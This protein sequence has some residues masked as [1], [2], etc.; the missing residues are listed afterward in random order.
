[1]H[2]QLQP[3]RAQRPIP[4]HPLVAGF[5]MPEGSRPQNQP[6]PLLLPANHLI[7]TAAFAFA[8][9]QPMLVLEQ[10][11]ETGSRH[12]FGDDMRGERGRFVPTV[13]YS[14]WTFHPA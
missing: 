4:P 5:E 1:M 12:R 6:Q 13:R 11:L 14:H 3:F 8:R 2:H 10:L 7:K 9:T